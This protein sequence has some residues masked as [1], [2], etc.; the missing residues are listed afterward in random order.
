MEY[1]V[2]EPDRVNSVASALV[3]MNDAPAG[4]VF[5]KKTLKDYN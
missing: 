3:Y 2:I 5:P 4:T 1:G